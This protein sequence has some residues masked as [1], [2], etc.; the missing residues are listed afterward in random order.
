[1]CAQPM[2][3]PR[4]WS[5]DRLVESLPQQLTYLAHRLCLAFRC[6]AF[7]TAALLSLTH[8][9]LIALGTTN[10]AP[11]TFTAL[12]TGNGLAFWLGHERRSDSL[13]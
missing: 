12:C 6:F 3:T 13:R 5:G 4:S 7:R 8:L 9:L 2:P 10:T 1:M 11:T